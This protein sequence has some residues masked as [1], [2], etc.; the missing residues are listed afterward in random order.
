ML[1]GKAIW[2]MQIDEELNDD[3]QLPI[4]NLT[5]KLLV[6]RG[7][8]NTEKAKKF[9]SP[10][11]EDLYDPF[12][13][14]DMK[15]AV[16][17]I[18]EA[19]VNGEMILVF[20]DYDADGVTSTALLVEALREKDAMVDF[21]IPNRFTEGYGPNENAFR[22]AYEAGVSL[23]I[24]VDTGIAAVEEARIAKELG[25]D[26]IITD[27][28][29][30]Q[31]ELPEA[32]AIIHPKIP[33]GYPFGELAGVGVS[34][35]LAQ[36]ILGSVPLHLIELAAIGTVADLVTLQDENRVIVYYGL[37]ALT[38]TNR[39]GIK[40]LKEIAS[41]EGDVTEEHIG[42]AIGPR[43]NAVGRLQ[44][45]S[46]A[47]ELLLEEDIDQAKHIAD[48][49]QS[50][51]QQRQQIVAEITQEAMTIIQE[52]NDKEDSVFVVAKEGWNPGV[53]G[54]VASRLVNEYNKPAIVLA[55]DEER[56]EAKGSARSIEAFNLFENCMEL[57]SLFISFGGHSQAAGMTLTLEN[58]DKLR[59][60]LNALAQEKLTEK[61]FSP[62]L[63]VDFAVHLSELSLDTIHE[64]GQLSPF[65]MGNPKPL[66][67]IKSQ[68]PS[69][70]RQI[71]SKLNHLKMSFQYEQT[72]LDVI[73]FSMGDLYPKISP[74]SKIA[75]VGELGINEWNG[76]KKMQMMLKDLKVQEWQMFDYR[77]TRHLSKQMSHLDSG[78]SKVCLHY[79]DIS[80]N[81]LWLKEKFLCIQAEE[82]SSQQKTSNGNVEELLLYDLP[83]KLE[84]LTVILKSVK[85]KF[86][87]VYFKTDEQNYFSQT[88]T[89]D[90]FKTFYGMIMKRGLLDLKKERTAYANKNGWSNEFLDFIIKVFLELQFVK[91]ENGVLYYN[92]KPTKKDLTDSATYQLKLNQ[93]EVEKTLYYSSYTELKN[94]FSK[95]LGISNLKEEVV[96]GL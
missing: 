27:H 54:I 29:E 92:P 36:A 18:E 2:R 62:I 7:I 72:N 40:M 69:E 88:P 14:P 91:I 56:G 49:I 13:F 5:K 6:K 15:K 71:G 11:L 57:K 10:N 59:K 83:P 24:T 4:S 81:D 34:F 86:I 96:H 94:W 16:S 12:L 3:I 20:G 38:S 67:E 79:S 85:P 90:H 21:Y 9:L 53:L 84:D 66:F 25:M 82:W 17:R 51:N 43:L 58:V 22:Q 46:L 23:I 45:A 35:K 76:R 77:G 26:L 74:H 32:L 42:F 52:S 68:L 89:R 8:R 33:E 47:V 31:E 30:P 55:I 78:K 19:I 60:E 39:P 48:E 80:T 95:Q 41:I 50:L 87:H 65:G 63:S 28:H 93:V 73:G 75:I 70:I 37:Q 1:E 61:D 44:D 64:I